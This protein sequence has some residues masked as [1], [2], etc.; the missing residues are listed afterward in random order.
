MIINHI[1]NNNKI[2]NINNF[3]NKYQN[4]NENYNNRISND[5]ININESI[6]KSKSIKSIS[7]SDKGDVSDEYYKY[8][9]N[10]KKCKLPDGLI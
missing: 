10:V 8:F 9:R 1:K 7:F 5:V 4:L 6:D 2:L 3:I